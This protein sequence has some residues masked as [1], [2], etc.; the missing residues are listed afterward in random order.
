MESYLA[1]RV[2][3]TPLKRIPR[4]KFL[5]I[6]VYVSKEN[7]TDHEDGS[8]SIMLEEPRKNTEQILLVGLSP[9]EMGVLENR[10][11]WTLGAEAHQD[12]LQEIAFSVLHSWV[13]NPKRNVVK[14]FTQTAG[15][16]KRDFLFTI[17]VSG[18]EEML[19]KGLTVTFQPD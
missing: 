10:Y 6:A 2:W 16:K 17:P 15:K 13:S 9:N 14:H 3:S 18:L 8:S 5:E 4:Q 12:I 11:E 1:Y 7:V 19:A